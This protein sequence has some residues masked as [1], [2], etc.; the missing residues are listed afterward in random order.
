MTSTSA[1]PA[2]NLIAVLPRLLG[3]PGALPDDWAPMATTYDLTRFDS[4]T[5]FAGRRCCAD[6]DFARRRSDAAALR[7]RLAV[8]GLP[9]DYARLGQPLSTVAMKCWWQAQTHAA[10]AWSFASVTKPWLSVIEDPQRTLPVRVFAEATLPIST[11]L[12]AQLAAR[13]VELH[14]NSALSSITKRADVLTVIVRNARFTGDVRNDLPTLCVT[15]P[16]TVACCWLP[17][18]RAFRRVAFKSFAN[19]RCR[20]CLPPMRCASWNLRLA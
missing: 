17:T 16:P 11:G 3:Q 18:H 2:A 10:Q 6:G 20:P 8:C 7:E 15:Q 14:E 1:N 5:A 12:R 4:D 19:A 13:N 9:Y